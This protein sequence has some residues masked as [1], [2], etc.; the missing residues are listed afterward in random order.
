MRTGELPTLETG[1]NI[2][3]SVLAITWCQLTDE[4][5]WISDRWKLEV[6]LKL[7]SNLLPDRR[8]QVNIKQMKT[9]SNIKNHFL[10]ITWCQLTDESRW[11][12]DRWPA[13]TTA[14]SSND[15]HQHL[16]HF[17]S[18]W[19]PRQFVIMSGVH[20]YVA[21]FLSISHLLSWTFITVV[22]LHRET[23]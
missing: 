20:I 22:F 4:S 10:S 21:T 13:A 11:I 14:T 15:W 1:S 3:N 8:E 19:I 2:K 5:R 17:F 23:F 7:I 6:I 12:S 9:G 16:S 18:S